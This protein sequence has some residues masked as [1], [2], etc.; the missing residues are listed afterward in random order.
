MT[1]SLDAHWLLGFLL[2]FVRA[3]AWLAFV[4]PFA[5]RR[6]IP[7]IALV[8]VAGGLAVLT[9]PQLPAGAVPTD[10]PGLIGAVV[11]QVAMG[12]AL[13]LS[14]R[15][16]LAA[17]TAA[18][19][20]VDLFGGIN[21]PPSMDPL[22]ENQTPLVGQ[23]YEQVAV[24]LLFVTNGEMLL[25]RGFETSFAATGLSLSGTGRLAGTLSADLATFF[26]A[27]L[28]IAAPVIVVLFTAQIGL[29]LL[30]KAAPLVNVWW[31]GFPVQ[32]LLSLAAVGIAIHVVPGFLG[33]L[34]DRSLQDIGA[35]FGGR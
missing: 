31:L 25:V 20:F 26:T 8:G 17:V 7:P 12:S 28:E 5:N 24:A 22:D 14:V 19:S 15:I 1:V 9:A 16:L 27:A 33:H 6:V 21:L 3:G 32:V 2:A 13:G 29:A 10:T 35:M 18:G 30:A 34:V 4:P 23:F 11:V